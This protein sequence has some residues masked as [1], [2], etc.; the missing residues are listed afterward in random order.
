MSSERQHTER[1][2]L[3]RVGAIWKPKP[4]AKSFGSGS[5]TI[6]G[7]RQRFLILKNDRKVD[8]SKDPD[9][10]LVSSEPP[11]IDEYARGRVA[12]PE[13]AAD[14]SDDGIPF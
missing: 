13:Q 2:P 11:E 7:M 5:V 1:G 10:V 6:D 4:G 14:E 12:E 8:G 9:Y 3:R